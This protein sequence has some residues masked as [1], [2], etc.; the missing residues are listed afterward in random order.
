MQSAI[1]LRTE[2]PPGLSN[3]CDNNPRMWFGQD[4]AQAAVALLLQ[5]VFMHLLVHS[6]DPTFFITS[7][8]KVQREQGS[9]CNSR[10]C[11][12]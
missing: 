2:Q 7:L 11:S 12:R 5:L 10:V 8:I 9:M 4:W 3:Q 6:N 1:P